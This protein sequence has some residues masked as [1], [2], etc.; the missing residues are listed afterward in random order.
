MVEPTVSAGYVNSLLKVVAARGADQRTLL[1]RAGIDA[2][3]LAKPDTRVPFARFKTLMRAAKEMLEDPALALHFG[4][5]SPFDEMSIVGLVCM[6]AETM[7]QAFEQMNRY[8]RLVV[9]VEGHESGDRF[10]I[11]PAGGGLCWLEDRRK[12]PNDFPELTE[13]TWARFVA[14]YEKFFPGRPHYV[15]AV[16]MPHAQP[17]YRAEYERIFKMPV[18]FGSERNALLITEGWLAEP[19]R[20]GNPYV[21]GIFSERAAAL[22]KS[23]EDSKTLKGRIERLLIPILHTGDLGMDA[24]AKR[25]G[26]SRATLYRKLREEGTSYD[27]LLDDLRHRMALHYLDGKKVSVNQAAYLVGFSDPSVFSRAFKRWTGKSPAQRNA[28]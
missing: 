25:I 21:F 15:K 5:N 6:A 23:L 7:G 18:V 8:A 14:P 20:S 17:A 1:A 26:L 2:Q 12:N 13:S 27:G 28:G 11:V 3:A 19:T 4:E 22:L 9:E 24:V 16:H 10:A